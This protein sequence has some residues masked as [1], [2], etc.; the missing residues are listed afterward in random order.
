[1]RGNEK[2]QLC[3]LSFF[4]PFSSYCAAKAMTVLIYY[5]GF[6]FAGEKNMSRLP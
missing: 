2:S 1:M 4:F 6:A 5:T 3:S